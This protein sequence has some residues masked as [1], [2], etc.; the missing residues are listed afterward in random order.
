MNNNIAEKEEGNLI[1]VNDR[2]IILVGTAHVSRESVEQVAAVI[3][4]Q[5]PDTVCVELC[6]SRF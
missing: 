2:E 4:A 3:E 1:R 5:K 6:P